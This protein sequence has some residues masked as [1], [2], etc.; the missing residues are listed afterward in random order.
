[1]RSM[2]E[3]NKFFSVNGLIHFLNSIKLFLLA[4][5][6]VATISYGIEPK[7]GNVWYALL[8]FIVAIGGFCIRQWAE[9]LWTFFLGHGILVLYCFFIGR[10]GKEK[11]IFVLYAMVDI[12]I[13]FAIRKNNRVKLWPE[14]YSI[15]LLLLCIPCLIYAGV[16]N[17]TYIF[18]LFMW[19]WLPFLWLH[20]FNLYLVK[21]ECYYRSNCL[22]TGTIKRSSLYKEGG[23]ILGIFSIC[24]AGILYVAT[25]ISTHGIGKRIL[26]ICYALLKWLLHFVHGEREE[27][28][29]QFLELTPTPTLTAQPLDE[30]Q[31]MGPSIIE[32]IAK[33]I[34]SVLMYF[35][36]LLAVIFVLAVFAL[37]FYTIWKSFYEKKEDIEEEKERIFPEK[38]ERTTVQRKHKRNWSIW[39]KGYRE[40]I[41]RLFKKRVEQSW[42]RD[43][44]E[45]NVKT[46]EELSQH[47]S[48]DTTAELLALYQKAR[49]S[50]DT[51]T[52]EEFD[53]LKEKLR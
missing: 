17:T 27:Y 15:A 25:Q 42:N 43:Y 40:K 19:I 3:K 50:Q 18:H 45:K 53:C 47:M 24:S 39:N 6:I 12:G 13:S 51:I 34:M 30:T 1:M 22:T 36:K 33:V 11:I 35:L 46:A 49:Y 14:N 9:R 38:R 44:G 4:F 37:F 41:R 16:T 26:H 10:N 29:E 5:F 28:T 31:S 32:E 20:F 7:R 21:Q 2:K 52:K 48:A 23:V 8:L